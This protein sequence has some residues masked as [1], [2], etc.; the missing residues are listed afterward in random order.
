MKDD[1]AAFDELRAASARPASRY[2]VIYDMENPW[3]ILL[4]HL[5]KMK[6]TC[7]HLNLRACAELAAGQNQNALNNV[8][9]MLYLADTVKTEPILIS[10]L[11]RLACVQIAMQSV[12]EGLAE[13]RWNDAGLPG[14]A[15]SLRAVRLHGRY[16]R[17]VALRARG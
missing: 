15:E 10:Y 17:A 3:G 1:E 5:A 8:K 13:Q 11:V 12:W 9:L 7:V 4:P 16:A 6:Q 2:P 14:I